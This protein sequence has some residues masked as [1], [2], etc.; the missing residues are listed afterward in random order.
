[1]WSE[2][3]QRKID[4]KDKHKQF[5]EGLKRTENKLADW[6]NSAGKFEDPRVY[7]LW[8]LAQKAGLDETEL[9]SIRVS[10]K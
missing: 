7:K 4:M 1:M 8:A 9:E 3:A 10:N 5:R 2:L 6:E